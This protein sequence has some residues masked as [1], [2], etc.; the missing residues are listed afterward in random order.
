MI[1]AQSDSTGR[2][3]ARLG[4]RIYLTLLA[5]LAL[6][7]CFLPLADHLGYEFA[8]LVALAAGSA[9]AAPGVAAARMESESSTR[10]LARALWFSLW[11]LA[12]PAG[13]VLLNGLRRPAC[14]PAGGFTLYLALA[15]PSALLSC[16]LGVAAV[17]LCPR[18]AD[19][20]CAA[21]LLV[22][23][24]FA[25]FPVVPDPQLRASDHSRA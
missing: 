15:V 3:G 20:L 18:P 19:L 24:A 13:I 8:E 4:P 25:L 12:L 14:D 16:T 5:L 1:A 6:V 11:S 2:I 21:V 10:A 23:S 17:F 22:P 7:C 9:G